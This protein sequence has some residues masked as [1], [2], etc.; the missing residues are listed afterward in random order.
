MNYE[1]TWFEAGIAIHD[2][3]DNDDCD[4]ANAHLV[5]SRH[6]QPSAIH[7]HPAHRRLKILFKNLKIFGNIF[8]HAKKFK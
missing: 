2:D 8:R 4:D 3:D 7:A 1:E 6:R 5:W